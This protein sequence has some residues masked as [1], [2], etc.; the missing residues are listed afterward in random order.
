MNK[1]LRVMENVF[2][3]L[4]VLS[5]F[6][7]FGLGIVGMIAAWCMILWNYIAIETHHA[8]SQI[9]FMVSMAAIGLL[10]LVGVIFRGLTVKVKQ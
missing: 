9:T 8:T 10:A 1:L 7:G 5:I 4:L 2:A 3:T 6:L